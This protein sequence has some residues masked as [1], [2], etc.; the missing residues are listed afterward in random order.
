MA[1]LLERAMQKRAAAIGGRL[2]LRNAQA[3]EVEAWLA[4]GQ[5]DAALSM[6]YDSPSLCWTCRFGPVDAGLAASADG[7]D[8]AAIAALEAKARAQ[9]LVLPLWRPLPVV[10]VRNGLNG[11]VANGYG[12]TAA[13]NAA[14]WWR[15]K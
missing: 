3:S 14:D 10:A 5:Y 11:V 13:W 2:D 12:L 9:S 1:S 8:V 7:G 15:S 6:H 4:A